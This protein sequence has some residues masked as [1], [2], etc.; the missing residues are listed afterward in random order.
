M[1]HAVWLLP[2]AAVVLALG[3]LGGLLGDD[4]GAV[5]APPLSL[6]GYLDEKLPEAPETKTIELKVDNQACYVCHGNYEGEELVVSHGVEKVGCIDCHGRSSAHRNDE[7]NITPP[8]K[9]YAPGRIDRMCGTCHDTHDAPPLKVLAKWQERCPEKTDPRTIVCT[10][11]HYQH[12]LARRTVVWNKKTGEL[13][14]HQPEKPVA[15]GSAAA[16]SGG[17]R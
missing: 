14:L 17:A 7:D 10:D 16:T 1:K 9:M 5:A 13:L 11:C 3:Y 2:V 6:E 15:A 8:D 12:R 4:A